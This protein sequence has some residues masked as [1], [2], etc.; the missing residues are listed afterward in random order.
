MI[1]NLTYKSTDG[2]V[3][4]SNFDPLILEDVFRRTIDDLMI[5]NEKSKQKILTLENECQKEKFSCRDKVVDM[6]E[7]YKESFE[8]LNALDTRISTVSGTM[9]EMGSQLENLNKPRQNL[10]ESQKIAKY[11]DKFMEGTENSGVF[12]DDSKLEQAA[13]VIYK[14]HLLSVDLNNEK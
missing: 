3:G 4:Q 1:E 9:S 6:E 12:A 2:Q 13:E 10:Y 14:L 8:H 5:I 7:L 11:F